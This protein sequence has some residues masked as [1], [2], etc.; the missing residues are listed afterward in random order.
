MVSPKPYPFER[1][2][3]NDV[4]KKTL[5]PSPVKYEFSE[6]KLPAWTCLYKME[7]F[8]SRCYY[9]EEDYNNVN[10]SNNIN[11]ENIENYC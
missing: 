2:N 9:N 5:F 8:N 7:D 1:L 11:E 4:I 10:N 6:T 3:K